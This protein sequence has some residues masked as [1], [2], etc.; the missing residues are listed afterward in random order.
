MKKLLLIIFAFFCINANAQEY[1]PMF[2]DGKMWI[3]STAIIGKELQVLSPSTSTA[4][5]C[6]DTIVGG[7]TCKKLCYREYDE[8]AT[9]KAFA[10]N[11]AIYEESG[12]VY[13]WDLDVSPESF[14]LML[15]FNMEKGY[16]TEDG[17]DKV[18]Y[19]DVV[20]VWGEE[21]SRI[22]FGSKDAKGI[23]M[24]WV[25]GVG[26]SI[27]SYF[28]KLFIPTGGIALR[29]LLECYENGRLIFT[30]DDFTKNLPTGVAAN[31]ADVPNA[32]TRTFDLSGRRIYSPKS[33]E[34]YIKSGEKHIA[35]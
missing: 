4:V 30:R 34:I 26:S 24:V 17:L 14:S 23:P 1:K 22:V 20:N 8:D 7:R 15:D 19:K 11:W 35:Q 6:G 9:K 12:R 16:I 2:T 32:D 5:V 21:R 31:V 13:V 25:E 18:K 29:Y 27:D 3:Y 10:Y 28:T 33:G